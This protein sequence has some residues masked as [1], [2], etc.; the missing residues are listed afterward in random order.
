MDGPE[1][2]GLFLMS[3][4]GGLVMAAA[5]DLIVLFLGIECLSIALYVLAASQ[6]RAGPSRRRP[7]SSTSCSAGSPSAFLL[8][9]IALLY[10]GDAARPA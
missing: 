5:N 9:G 2:Y 8:Y 1:I 10:G 3:A 6:P 4:L 7:A